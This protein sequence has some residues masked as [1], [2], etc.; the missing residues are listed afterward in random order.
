MPT[1]F[2]VILIDANG[3][4][5][6]IIQLPSPVDASILN[7][8]AS[9]ELNQSCMKILGDIEHLAIDL[10]GDRIARITPHIGQS[11]IGWGVVERAVAE[12]AFDFGSRV[13]V[14]GR[15]YP[16]QS[17]A[18]GPWRKRSVF[19]RSVLALVVRDLW[20]TINT[21]VYEHNF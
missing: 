2:N 16:Q 11:L 9:P 20:V 8:E 3:I 1:L 6:D 12:F 4:Y 7:A 15:Q 18:V 5:P 17:K 10:N 21:V 19:I 13:S 14:L